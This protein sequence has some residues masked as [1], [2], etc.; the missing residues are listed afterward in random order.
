MK[1][2]DTYIVEKLKLNKDTKDENLI[3]DSF[4]D[5]IRDEQWCKEFADEIDFGYGF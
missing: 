1:K 4:V 2:L 3:D 5:G